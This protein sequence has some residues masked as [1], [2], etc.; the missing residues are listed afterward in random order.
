[1]KLIDSIPSYQTPLRT[2][3]VI[4]YELGGIIRNLIY[5]GHMERQGEEKRK[6]AKLAEARI[7]LADLLT[8][9]HLLAEQMG[10]ELVDLEND[11]EERFLERMKE[12]KKGEL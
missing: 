11:G 4:T 6:R 1:M 3:Q 9:A 10:W 5:A 7:D 12:I 2:T 8:Q